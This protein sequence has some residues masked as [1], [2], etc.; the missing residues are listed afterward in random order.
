ML[1]KAP[2]QIIIPS[3]TNTDELDYDPLNH[4]VYVG[5][6]A[7]PFFVTVV[8]V[9]TETLVGQIPLTGSPEQPRFNPVDGFVYVSVPGPGL[10]LPAV[11][12][13]DTTKT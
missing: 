10:G 3:G 9:L 2:T 11:V 6:T 4:R 13:I 12:R 7:A 5:N 8:D 1:T